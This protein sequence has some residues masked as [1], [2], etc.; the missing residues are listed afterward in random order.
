MTSNDLAISDDYTGDLSESGPQRRTL[1]HATITKM[2]VG[3]MDNNTY[4]ITSKSSGEQLIID[5]AND[6][7]DILAVLRELGGSPT[8][9]FT[10]HQHFDH[11]QALEQVATATGA[12]TAAGRIDADELPVRPDTLVDDGDQLT[13]GDL[14]F[15]AIH[16]VGH[17]PGSIALALTDPADGVVHLF[18]GDSLFPGGVGKTWQPGDFDTLIDDVSTKVFDRFPDST[19]VYPG[20]GKDTTLGAERPA[21]PEWRERGW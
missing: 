5:A 3:P 16:L 17:T 7:D 10:T 2:S 20:H 8:L 6:G 14:T 12:P 15:T 21:L 1:S 4:I 18:T 11:W 19:V 13:V 9:I